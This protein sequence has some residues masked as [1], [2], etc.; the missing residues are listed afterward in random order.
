MNKLIVLIA[1]AI[2][3][4]LATVSL[5]K[6][7]I[8]DLIM[9]L[10]FTIFVKGTKKISGQ[11]ASVFQKVLMNKGMHFANFITEIIT[12]FLI[13]FFAVFISKHLMNKIPFIEKFGYSPS[14][15]EEQKQ[16]W[17]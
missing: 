11:A 5:V 10:L 12:W 2:T 13:V 9:P 14:P 3:I 6:S 15:L 4:G 16:N 17:A 1:T 7:L 8:N